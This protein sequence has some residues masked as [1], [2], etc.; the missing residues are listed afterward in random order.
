ML[1]PCASYSSIRVYVS[2][3]VWLW[4]QQGGHLHVALLPLVALSRAGRN[5]ARMM[6]RLDPF[7]L[8]TS[9]LWE[10]I[11]GIRGGALLVLGMTPVWTVLNPT[12]YPVLHFPH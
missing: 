10:C 5:L 3:V 8:L 9:N 1:S 4:I 12:L 2:V 11:R 7:Q 6:D